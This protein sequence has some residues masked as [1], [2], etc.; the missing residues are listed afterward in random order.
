MTLLG[1]AAAVL[2]R[3]PAVRRVPPSA[4]TDH[5]L[6]TTPAPA[7]GDAV[8]VAVPYSAVCPACGREATWTARKRPVFSHHGAYVRD[9]LELEVDCTCP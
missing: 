1:Y 6:P 9:R 4:T 7:R 8:I 3:T 2:A 5:G